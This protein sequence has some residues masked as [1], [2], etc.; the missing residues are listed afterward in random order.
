MKR[1]ELIAMRILLEHIEDDVPL[2]K[3]PLI[4]DF[5]VYGEQIMYR[6]EYTWMLIKAQP[7]F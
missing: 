7:Y 6:Q 5:V 1:K 3:L 2:R 4:V